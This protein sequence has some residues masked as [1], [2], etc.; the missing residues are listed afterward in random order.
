M[1]IVA[2]ALVIA[3]EPATAQTGIVGWGSRVFNSAW[4]EGSYTQVAAGHTHTV[5]LRIDGSIV[6]WGD[7]SY[8][9]T[10]VPALPPGLNYTQVAAGDAHTVALR[11]DGS[12]VAW[13]DNDSGQTNVPA[14]PPGLS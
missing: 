13:G 4:N 10:N 2:A 5:G 14:L 1:L 3:G 11:S 6:A 12:V 7:N 9:Q 8:G